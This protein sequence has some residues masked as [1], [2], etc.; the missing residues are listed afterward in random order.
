VKRV[1][2][3]LVS[4]LVPAYN[5]EGSVERAHA[6]I[7][8]VFAGLPD[9]DHEIL[10]MDNHS[11]DRT[12]SLLQGIA[13]R[14]SH[15]RVVRFAR[16]NG[17]D[18]SLLFAY[19]QARGDCSIQVDCDLQDPPDLIPEMLARWEQGHQVVYGVRR[20]LADGPVSTALRRW[21]YSMV[22]VLSEDELPL[23]A[24]EFRLVDGCILREL[25][26]VRDTN[27]YVR[28]LISAMG[29]SQ[30]GIEYDRGDRLAGE[31][32]FPLSKMIA[33]GLDGVLNHS[34]I[35]LRVASVVGLVV[36]LVTMLLIIGYMIGRLVFGQDWP[37]GFATTTLLLL[38]GITLNA[39]FLGVIGEYLGRIF[40]QLKGRAFPIVEVEIN[41]PMTDKVE[42]TPPTKKL[43]AKAPVSARP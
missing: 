5:E 20:S 35:P 39:L 18:R 43:A 36:G 9:Y 17:Y 28:G 14:D 10:F 21:Y 13:A 6:E 22:N 12:F 19:Q 3:P 8:R 40:M 25:R 31:S 30:I 24:G 29:F 4:V 7:S 23:N 2:R 37:A 26:K 33:L 42:R 34:L 32:K 15:V 11:T 16:N 41:R 27:P 38:L 1:R